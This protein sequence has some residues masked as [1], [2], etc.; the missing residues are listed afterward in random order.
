MTKVQNFSGIDISKNSFNVCVEHEGKL[1][2][3]KFVYTDDGMFNCLCFL[4]TGVHCVMEST[5]TYHC[6][7][8]YFLHRHGVPV[9]VVN[10]L[11]VKR[12]SQSLQLRAKTDKADSQMLLAY[13][14]MFTPKL[15]RPKPDGY[16]EL[17]QLIGLH[18]LLGRQAQAA[19]NQLE[20]IAHSVIQSSF[21]VEMLQRRVEQLQEDMLQLEQRMELLAREQ[22]EKDFDCLLS[23]PGFGKKTAVILL[24]IT[25]GMQEFDSAKQVSAYI[26]ICPRVYQSGTS[27]KGAGK[28]CKMGMSLVRKLLYMCALSAKR[29]NKACREMYERLLTQGKSKKIALIAVANKLIKQAFAIVKR[30][31]VYDE[32]FFV[33][34]LAC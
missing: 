11:S 19:K 27:V 4:P 2:H 29:V 33:K 9:S 25:Q 34:K 3:K 22:S 6:R 28:I 5:G 30:K 18:E 7:L 23:I 12:F 21:A 24:A 17:Q 10:P 20:A 14:K 1:H 15:W 31:I 26:G 8:A 13:G 32:N 16:V